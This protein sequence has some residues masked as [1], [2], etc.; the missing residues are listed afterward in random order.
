ETYAYIGGATV[1]ASGDVSVKAD[2]YES[3]TSV[4][5]AIGAGSVGVSGSAGISVLGVK[6]RAFIGDDEE[7]LT[8]GVADVV[9]EGNV[10]ITATGETH[11]TTLAGSIAAGSVGVGVAAA[12]TVVNKTTEA[13]LGRNAEVTGKGNDATTV[14]TGRFGAAQLGDYDKNSSADFSGL[15]DD[16]KHVKP[17]Q[18]RSPDTSG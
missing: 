8:S 13:Y 11:L 14:N 15:S 16:G 18:L 4:A 6:T 10:I 3:L 1:E 12:V 7:S 17:I 2:S 9:A 5:A